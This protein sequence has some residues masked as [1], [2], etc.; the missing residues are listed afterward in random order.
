MNN[1]VDF[2]I[3]DEALL[4]LDSVGIFGSSNVTLIAGINSVYKCEYTDEHVW[5]LSI[6]ESQ[7]FHMK[8]GVLICGIS[9]NDTTLYFVFLS[10]VNAFFS[11]HGVNVKFAGKMNSII[12]V[13]GGSI[14]IEDFKMDKQYYWVYP[15]IDAD[16]VDGPISVNFISSTIIN[17]TYKSD[18]SF[19]PFN[20]S[21]IYFTDT[22]TEIIS[23]NMS[24]CSFYNNSFYLFGSMYARGGVCQ[25]CGFQESGIIIF[26]FSFI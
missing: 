13:T 23:L 19:S 22:G 21:V 1:D 14:H 2:I 25:F 10:N 20:S 12:Y 3:A 4:T 16:A 17:N 18:S 7:S 15:L 11:F 6:N 8:G 5:I 26:F 9:S 24:L